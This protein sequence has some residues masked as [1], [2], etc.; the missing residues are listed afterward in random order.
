MRVNAV[1]LEF[2]LRRDAFGKT[3]AAFDDLR[4]VE[5]HCP[6]TRLLSPSG[7]SRSPDMLDRVTYI[8]EDW[9][10]GHVELLS[11]RPPTSS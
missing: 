4:S 9:W 3:R 11:G 7:K 5:A 6:P 2:S 10:A 1:A 8:A